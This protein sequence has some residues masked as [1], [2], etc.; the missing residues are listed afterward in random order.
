VQKPKLNY[1]F[2]GGETDFGLR[3]DVTLILRKAAEKK[4]KPPKIQRRAKIRLDTHKM[5]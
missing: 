5:I 4:Q 1:P 3:A 2:M